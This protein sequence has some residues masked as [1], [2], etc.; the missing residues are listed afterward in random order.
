MLDSVFIFKN[1]LFK[2]DFFFI[3]SNFE[4]K[5]KLTK[6]KFWMRE[7]KKKYVSFFAVW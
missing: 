3:Q 7:N 6:K 5:L 4:Q 1:T 2:N